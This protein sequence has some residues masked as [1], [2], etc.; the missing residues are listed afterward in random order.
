MFKV[1][2]W[3][4]I[5]N[6]SCSLETKIQAVILIAKY[7]SPVMIIRE[8]QLFTLPRSWTNIMAEVE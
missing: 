4:Q 5:S 6:M 7:E 3:F 8:L 2:F 1:L